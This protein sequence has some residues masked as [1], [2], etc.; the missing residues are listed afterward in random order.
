M[1]IYA[2]HKDVNNYQFFLPVDVEVSQ[3]GDLIMDCQPRLAAWSPPEV[4]IHNPKL[5]R[6]NFLG[7]GM[8]GPFACDEQT[9]DH[10]EMAELLEMSGELLPLL[11]E[12]EMFYVLNVLEC[13]NALDR[14]KSTWPPSMK[15]KIG[16]PQKYAFHCSRIP[17]TPLFKIPETSR[18]QIF[19]AENAYD[20]NYEFKRLY[21]TLGLTGLYF[22]KL[23]SDEE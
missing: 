6:G 14:D 9:R 19:C 8:G 22:E 1:T 11:H 18:S 23:W 12:G 2:V 21:E 15:S 16:M 3:R 17:E 10:D 7:V 5:K 13:V 20:S 4:Y